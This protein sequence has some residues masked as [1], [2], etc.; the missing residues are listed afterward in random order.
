MCVRRRSY[1]SVI[2]VAF[3]IVAAQ[4]PPF[5]LAGVM[6]SLLAIVCAS[7]VR[8]MVPG[9]L[10]GYWQ[11]KIQDFEKMKKEQGEERKEEE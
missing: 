10:D 6:L 9:G 4:D 2:G 5:V 1:V 7:T 11:Q 8:I 3:E